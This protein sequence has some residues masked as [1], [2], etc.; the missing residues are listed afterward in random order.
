MRPYDRAQS[1]RLT[2]IA[3]GD[4]EFAVEQAGSTWSTLAPHNRGELLGALAEGWL[5]LGDTARANTYLDRMIAE[6]PDTPY[7]KAA[8][9]HRADPSARAP[10]TCLGCH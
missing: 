3:M 2:K 10:L 1:D 4:F 6:L 9:Q 8:A 7:A 5:T